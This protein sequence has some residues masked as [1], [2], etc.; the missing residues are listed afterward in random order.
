MNIQVGPP[1]FGERVKA[2]WAIVPTPHGNPT[3]CRAV[4]APNHYL[5][6][7]VI[8]VVAADTELS[9]FRGVGRSPIEPS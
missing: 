4:F 3:I 7:Q 6:E 8:T 9:H 5:R 1:P 2:D